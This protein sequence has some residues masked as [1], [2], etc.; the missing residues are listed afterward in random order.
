MSSVAY[1]RL[2]ESID[3]HRIDP[4]R[5]TYWRWLGRQTFD[6]D[7]YWAGAVGYQTDTMFGIINTEGKA[8]MRDGKVVR[9]VYSGSEEPIP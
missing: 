9:W 1:R 8:L 2:S 6:G 4:A 7:T 3:L 5:I